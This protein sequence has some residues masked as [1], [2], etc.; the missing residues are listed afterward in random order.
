MKKAK[1]N[2]IRIGD[3]TNLPH[4]QMNNDMKLTA[5]HDM[6]ES[7]GRARTHQNNDSTHSNGGSSQPMNI[8]GNDTSLVSALSI[9]QMEPSSPSRSAGGCG[10]ASHDRQ[11]DGSPKP[12][13]VTAAAQPQSAAAPTYFINSSNNSSSMHNP[14]VTF[15]MPAVVDVIQS[16]NNTN[17]NMNCNIKSTHVD[18]GVDGMV[19]V[20]GRLLLNNVDLLL[21]LVP[22]TSMATLVERAVA[23]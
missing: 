3:D 2:S 14:L 15:A 8:D 21:V 22:T 5:L 11:H 20:V 13:T 4:R 12:T 9:P 18:V 23:A 16:S 19:H 10:V 6:M 17:T 1:A 7:D